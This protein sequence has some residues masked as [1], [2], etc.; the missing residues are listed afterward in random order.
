MPLGS[1]RPSW[2][3]L[4][5]ALL[6][7]LLATGCAS[8]S[9]LPRLTAELSDPA[10]PNK[11]CLAIVRRLRHADFRQTSNALIDLVTS[12][13][14]QPPY[15]YRRGYVGDDLRIEERVLTETRQIVEAYFSSPGTDAEKAAF[16][17]QLLLARHDSDGRIVL[18]YLIEK[19]LLEKYEHLDRPNPVE[20]TPIAAIATAPDASPELRMSALRVLMRYFEPNQYCAAA[21][22]Q[23]RALPL[24]EPH[25]DPNLGTWSMR[26]YYYCS[27]VGSADRLSPENRTALLRLGFAILR[28]TLATGSGNGYMLAL[29]LER[30][31]QHGGAFRPD[32]NAPQ[33]QDARGLNDRFHED[34]VRNA[35]VWAKA[36]GY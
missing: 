13:R 25:P 5:P 28:E 3:S 8:P 23:V 19:H 27:I 24:T 4:L 31:V 15:Y 20:E 7:G 30:E 14:F 6:L 16:L 9:A 18:L 35:L 32:Q 12:A 21:L 11:R 26:E 36:N 29:D 1:H 17:C 10:T 34:T 2:R 33:Y 22:A